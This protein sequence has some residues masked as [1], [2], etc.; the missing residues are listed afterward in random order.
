[1][2]SRRILAYTSGRTLVALGER[3]FIELPTDGCGFL[4]A[5]QLRPEN[6]SVAGSSQHPAANDATDVSENISSG[7]AEE[8]KWATRGSAG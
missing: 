5:R 1:M 2:A 3:R 8:E 4:V 6:L 7:R